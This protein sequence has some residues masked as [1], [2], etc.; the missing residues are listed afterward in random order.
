MRGNEAKPIMRAQETSYNYHAQQIEREKM[1]KHLL[2]V[3]KSILVVQAFTYLP[4]LS[5]FTYCGNPRDLEVKT[6]DRHGT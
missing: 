3:P 4:I 6:Q 1:V 5:K 2:Q